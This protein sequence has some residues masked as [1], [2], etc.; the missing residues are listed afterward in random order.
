MSPAIEFHAVTQRDFA[1][2]RSNNGS[3]HFRV[4]RRAG[5]T[6]IDGDWYS[7]RWELARSAWRQIQ[8]AW[9]AECVTYPCKGGE[10]GGGRS[11][12]I[13]TI[14]PSREDYWRSFLG[15]LLARREAWLTW[16]GRRGFVPQTPELE[17][18]A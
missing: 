4:V 13:V 17:P 9:N 18:A 5:R 15:E 10:C 3:I 11:C 1:S 16:N 2:V 6:D 8:S 12:M 7:T 14:E